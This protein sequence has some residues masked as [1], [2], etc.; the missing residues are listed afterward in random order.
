[1][2]KLRELFKRVAPAMDMHLL[3]FF[4]RILST[5][6]GRKLAI[7]VITDSPYGV[8]VATLEGLGDC[9]ELLGYFRVVLPLSLHNA[10]YR[11]SYK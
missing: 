7:D 10:R 9:L 2:H 3:A 6:K 11:F 1:M 4:T 8:L 5:K